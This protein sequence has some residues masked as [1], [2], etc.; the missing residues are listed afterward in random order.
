MLTGSSLQ[1][2]A[3]TWFPLKKLLVMSLEQ[4]PC[5]LLLVF[6]YQA[7]T[8]FPQEV[9]GYELRAGT[10]RT[11]SSLSVSSRNLAHAS[12]YLAGS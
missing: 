11:G 8:W 5:E 4:G 12:K 1:Y 6:Q 7:G 2:Q 9:I 10:M 3:G